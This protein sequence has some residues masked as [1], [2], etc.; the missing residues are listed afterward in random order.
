MIEVLF[1]PRGGEIS[2]APGNAT[3]IGVGQIFTAD[4]GI[5]FLEAP[6]IGDYSFVIRFSAESM[7][8]EEQPPLG[9][10]SAEFLYTWGGFGGR[11]TTLS[12]SEGLLYVARDPGS[13]IYVFD[14]QGNYIREIGEPGSGNGQL[15]FA[16]GVDADGSG[17]YILQT[18]VIIGFKCSSHQVSSA[19]NGDLVAVGM[20][21][22]TTLKLWLEM[23]S[24]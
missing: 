21:S 17:T 14:Y 2:P 7:S 4:L 8:P 22:S 19:P 15:L 9:P 3:N 16:N 13:A 1:G 12:A 6:G 11:P 23:A 5:R 24:A 20:G 18:P 10:I